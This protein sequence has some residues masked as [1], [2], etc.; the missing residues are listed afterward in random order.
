MYSNQK[1]TE[2][3]NRC[4]KKD[5]QMSKTDC[6]CDKWNQSRNKLSLNFIEKKVVEKR[7]KKAKVVKS[8]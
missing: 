5:K 8:K 2:H 4:K 1:F 3:W 7:Q 6:I